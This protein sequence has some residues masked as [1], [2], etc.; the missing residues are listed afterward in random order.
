MPVTAESISAF[1]GVLADR[2]RTAMC[3]ALLDGRAWTAGEL[4][5]T[6]EVARSTASEHISALLAAGVVTDER[7]GRHRYVRLAGPEVAEVIETLGSVVGVPVRP[8]SLRTARATG[9]LAAARTCYDHLAGAWGVAVFEGLT[10][11][12]LLRTVDGVVLT[13]AGRAWFAEVCAEPEVSAP[14]RRPAVR[15][16]L[17]WTE[18]RSHLGGA[19]GAALLRRGL[20]DGWF[21]RDAAVPRALTITPHGRRTLA[22]LLGVAV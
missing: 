9:R 22:D 14:G 13:P 6:A 5:R 21:L 19:A 17:D 2:S 7:Q 11:A 15:A 1:A 12:G 8:T 20:E 4:A 16:C 10:R 3:L 18:R